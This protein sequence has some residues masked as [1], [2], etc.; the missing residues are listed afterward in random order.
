MTEQPKRSRWKRRVE[1]LTFA[2]IGFLS[3]LLTQGSPIY[4]KFSRDKTAV[5]VA[6]GIVGAAAGGAIGWWWSAR[7]REPPATQS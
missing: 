4:W 2:L 6:C 5:A 3:S 1:A 7:R